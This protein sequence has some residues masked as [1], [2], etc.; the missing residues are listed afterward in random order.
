MQTQPGDAT[1]GTS[2]RRIPCQG[3]HS[4]HAI[5][6]G[7]VLIV[8]FPSLSPAAE[9][10]LPEAMQTREFIYETAPFPECHAS[11]IVE[12]AAGTLVASWFGG[13]EEKHPDV[14]IWV[15]RRV[16]GKWSTPVEVATGEQPDGDRLPTWNPVLFQPRTGPLMLF[17]K[18]GPTPSNWWGEMMISHDDGKTWQDRR[19]LPDHGIG[20]VKNKPV[21]LKD[22]SIWC[23]SSSEDDGWR[24][25]LEVTRDL[26]QTFR[27]IGPLNDGREVGAIQPSL[28]TYPDGKLQ[29]LCRNRNGN[30]D[31]WQTWSDDGGENWSE[32]SSTGLPNPNSGTDAVT[33]AD[34]RQLLVYNHTHRRGPS[35][36]GRE[37]LN[38]AISP[39]GKNWQ[40]ALVLE[41]SPGEYSYPAVIQSRDGHV[42]I[43]YTW[44]RERIRHVELDPTRLQLTPIVDSQWPGL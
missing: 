18:V 40:A 5:R 6:A 36:R 32:F 41:N 14:G 10:P 9:N 20:P 3:L 37:M 31:L 4:R 33:L 13:T 42:H 34:G 30:G 43:T 15:S 24:V 25:H 7:L 39:G 28:L 26:A 2:S 16:D 19:R 23:P 12:T 1:T 38:V 21:Q 29:L 44:R 22:G 17:F 35:P 8:V 27:S 11:T